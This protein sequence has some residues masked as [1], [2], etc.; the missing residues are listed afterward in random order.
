MVIASV[1]A[2]PASQTFAQSVPTEG[3]QEG[4][5]KDHPQPGHALHR[6]FLPAPFATPGSLG[7]AS[8]DEKSAE[9]KKHNDR[10]MSESGEEIKYL[11]P[12][13]RRPERAIV[14]KEKGA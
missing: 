8:T 12:K 5:Q 11:V 14:H 10:L 4:G 1:I 13:G 9:D 6:I 2:F 7:N 3:Q